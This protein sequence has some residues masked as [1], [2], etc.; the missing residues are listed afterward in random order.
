[1]Q[2]GLKHSYIA[3]AGTICFVAMVNA[4]NFLTYK[5]EERR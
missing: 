3:I 1:M 2:V 5:I 4:P